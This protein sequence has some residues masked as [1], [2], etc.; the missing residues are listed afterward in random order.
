MSCVFLDVFVGEGER[1]FLLFRRLDP[2]ISFS[3][4]IVEIS[5]LKAHR[6]N[7]INFKVCLNS[8]FHEV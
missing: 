1:D 5:L 4:L 2:F 3:S 7:L 6:S 8:I